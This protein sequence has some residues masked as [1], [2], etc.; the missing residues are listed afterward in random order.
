MIV[1][2]ID[3]Q[4]HARANNR[5]RE[6]EAVLQELAPTLQIL[7]EILSDQSETIS[8]PTINAFRADL[9]Q[10]INTLVPQ[11]SKVSSDAQRLVA[12]SD[13]AGKHLT[14]IEEHFGAQLRNTPSNPSPAQVNT[15]AQ[16]PT[17]LVR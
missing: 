10:R 1:Y 3:K 15:Q 4:S 6:M 11:V 5:I 12:V 13:Q 9:Q 7:S 2:K 16:N 8:S 14:A 17:Q